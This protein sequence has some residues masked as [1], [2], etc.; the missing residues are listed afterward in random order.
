MSND[1]SIQKPHIQRRDTLKPNS[2]GKEYIPENYK[3]FAQGLEKQLADVMVKEMTKS[4]SRANGES[5]AMNYYNDLL[6]DKRSE[7]LTK[8]NGGLGLQDLILDQIYPRKFRNKK[9]YEAS[10]QDKN[11]FLKQKVEMAGP[12]KETAIEMKDKKPAI[13][14][15]GKGDGRE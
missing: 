11:Q 5:T 4:I 8:T 13:R 1:I 15:Y 10:L 7:G 12:K 6:N 14:I 9:A 2:D 3:E